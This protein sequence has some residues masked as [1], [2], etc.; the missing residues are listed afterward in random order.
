MKK[1]PHFLPYPTLELEGIQDKKILQALRN[2][3]RELFV[4]SEFSQE[5]YV[6]A[7]LPIACGQTISQPFI[8]AYMTEKL[9][10]QAT[11]TVLEIGTGS[12]FQAAVLAQLVQKV[13]TIEVHAELS[14]TAQ[15]LLNKLGYQNVNYR[16]G[17]GKE[18]W[19]DYAPFDKIILTAVAKEIPTKLVKQLKIGGKLILPLQVNFFEQDLVLITKLTAGK[20]KQ[21][22]LLPV[23]F[24]PLV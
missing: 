5:A 16:V 21:E 1:S 10:L 2:L 7:P 19:S 18:G 15:K 12:G 11:D 13:Y 14:Q 8:V 20:I 4:S 9:Q 23:R 22:K 24:V 6:N 17:D 3:P